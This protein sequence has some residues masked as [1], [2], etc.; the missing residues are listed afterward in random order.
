MPLDR[1]DR[2]EDD[3]IDVD[4]VLFLSCFSLSCVIYWLNEPGGKMGVEGVNKG[5]QGFR[6]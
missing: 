2:R 1:I 4:V 6:I 3:E 5:N